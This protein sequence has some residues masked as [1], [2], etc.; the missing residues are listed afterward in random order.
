MIGT[1]VVGGPQ[2]Q[3]CLEH[4]DILRDLLF[5]DQDVPDAI[6]QAVLASGYEEKTAEELRIPDWKEAAKES[7]PPDSIMVVKRLREDRV[8]KPM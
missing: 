1:P 5:L 2:P 6:K 3:P 8:L 4:G 7:A